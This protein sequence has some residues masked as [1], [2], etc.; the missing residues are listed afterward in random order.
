MLLW[1]LS[2]VLA[3]L[4]A[5]VAQGWLRQGLR[6]A[7]PPMA[8][9]ALAIAAFTW[10][11]LVTAVAVLSIAGVALP[12]PVGFR[13]VVAPLVWVGSIL[14]TALALWGLLWKQRPWMFVLAGALLAAAALPVMV[15]TVWAAGFRPGIVWR[16]ELLIAASAMLVIGNIGALWLALSES[17]LNGER[18]LLWRLSAAALM[19]LVTMAAQEVAAL[20]AGLTM[21]V[22]S[23]FQHQTPSAVLALIA[24]GALPLVLVMLLID[25]EVRRAAQ[26]EQRRGRD[27]SHL[28]LKK[29]EKRRS[30]TREA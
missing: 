19:G 16:Q 21:Q 24:G 13:T 26:R 11:S 12:F 30:R 22:G 17:A 2:A 4:A 7:R 3:V 6:H 1:L 15:A 29:R 10:G 5:Y 27:T 28:K 8:F 18:R 25:L 20:A 14:A 23:V 9:G